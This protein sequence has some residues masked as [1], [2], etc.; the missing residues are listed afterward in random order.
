METLIDLGKWFAG[1]IV[2]LAVFGYYFRF[3]IELPGFLVCSLFQ[4]E[5]ED[6][7]APR[8]GLET[9]VVGLLFWSVVSLVGYGAWQA[10]RGNATTWSTSSLMPMRS[11]MAWLWCEGTSESTWLPSGSRSV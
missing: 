8:A 1:S 7:E 10:Y 11:P 9:F 3:A 4:G 2:F 5:D 6:D